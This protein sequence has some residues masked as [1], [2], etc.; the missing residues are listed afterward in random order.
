M[1]YRVL[2]GMDYP[3]TKGNKRAEP[4]DVVDD[5]PRKSVGWLLSQGHIEKVEGGDD[6]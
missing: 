6:D 4:G 2:T 3:T 5:L 1:T